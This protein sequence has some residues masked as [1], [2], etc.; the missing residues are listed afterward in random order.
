MTAWMSLPVPPAV[1]NEPMSWALVICGVMVIVQNRNWRAATTIWPAKM[2]CVTG[3]WV[4]AAMAFVAGEELLLGATVEW[5][6]K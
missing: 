1:W 2:L 4:I 6:L 3:W 5:E